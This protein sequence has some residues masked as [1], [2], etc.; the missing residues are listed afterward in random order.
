MFGLVPVNEGDEK[1]MWHCQNCRTCWQD[2]HSDNGL[3]TYCGTD[4]RLHPTVRRRWRMTKVG[5][6]YRWV[7]VTDENGMTEI[8]KYGT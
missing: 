4:V 3:C 7:D 2:C 1:F 6:G 8:M 5:K